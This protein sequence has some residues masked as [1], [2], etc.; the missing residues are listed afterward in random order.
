MVEKHYAD[1]D[2]EVPDYLRSRPTRGY[3]SEAQVALDRLQ[4]ERRADGG[5][6]RYTQSLNGRFI[7]GLTTGIAISFFRPSAA[8]IP[9][10]MCGSILL[11]QSV[12]NSYPGVGL[13]L[14]KAG[15]RNGEVGDTILRAMISRA[16]IQLY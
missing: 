4:L 11:H 15:L 10:V 12:V 16:Y 14:G 2:K 1:Q 3:S 7:N 6:L 8:C 13:E 9:D 5:T